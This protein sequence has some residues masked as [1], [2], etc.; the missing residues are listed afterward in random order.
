MPDQASDSALM[1][2]I[3]SAAV[4]AAGRVTEVRQVAFTPSQAAHGPMRISEHDPGMAEAVIEVSD[5]IKGTEKGRKVLVRFPTS[6]DVRWYRYPKFQVGTSGVFIL[7]PDALTPGG[8]ALAAGVDAYN[9]SHP[10]DVLPLAAAERVKSAV[11]RSQK[12]G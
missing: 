12:S 11:E 10:D 2:R 1:E 8:T 7:Q 6:T 5:A 4:I 9:A 3:R